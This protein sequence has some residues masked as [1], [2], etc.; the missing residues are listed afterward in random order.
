MTI[1]VYSIAIIGLCHIKVVS[2]I[3][4]WYYPYPSDYQ[5]VTQN[6]FSLMGRPKVFH[7]FQKCFT[8]LHVSTVL[9]TFLLE[10]TNFTILQSK[11]EYTWII[12]M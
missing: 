12:Y 10:Y 4:V 11:Y 9:F 8:F 2:Y 5:R 3:E 1:A 6:D 7:D